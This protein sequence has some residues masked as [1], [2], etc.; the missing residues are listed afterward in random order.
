MARTVRTI[1]AMVLAPPLFLLVL[2]Q[3]GAFA[4]RSPMIGY[5]SMLGVW[6]IGMAALLSSGWERRMLIWVGVAYTIVAAPIIPFLGLLAVC[7]TGDC[8]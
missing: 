3:M 2:A 4:S 7:S 6:A 1:A 8:I 5:A